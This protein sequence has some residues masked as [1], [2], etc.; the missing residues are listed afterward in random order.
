MSYHYTF[1]YILIGDT[2]VGKTNICSQFINKVFD[3]AADSTVGVDFVSKIIPV[4]DQFIKLNIW[5]TGGT[6]NYRSIARS[7][8]KNTA[9]VLLVFDVTARKSFKDTKEWLEDVRKECDPGTVIILVANKVDLQKRQVSSYEAEMFAREN[10]LLYQEVSAR[11]GIN[12]SE[13]FYHS[14]AVVHDKLRSLIIIP[15]GKFGVVCHRLQA[16]SGSKKSIILLEENN[17]NNT[18]NEKQAFTKC[19][20]CIL[21]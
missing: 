4:H 9:V 12:I 10:Q 2:S 18:E 5:D 20:Q 21:L 7:Y 17:L 3:P 19:L 6:C 13:L 15:D 16:E 14:A 8:Y 11:T 1:K